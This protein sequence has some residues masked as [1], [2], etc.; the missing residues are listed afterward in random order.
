MRR[1]LDRDKDCLALA[2]LMGFFAARL[3]FA[4]T[5]GLGVDESYT[6]AIS[7]YLSLSYFDHPPLHLWITHFVALIVGETAAVRIPFVFLFVATTWIYYIFTSDLLGRRPALVAL[8]AL[9]VCPFF[10]ASAGGWIVPDGLLLFGLAVAASAASRVFFSKPLDPAS[11]WRRWLLIG[12]GLGLAGLSKYSAVLTAAGLGAF[13]LLSPKQRYW[14]KHP[15]PYVSAAVAIVITTPA[16]VWNAQH[17]WASFEFQG[18]RGAPSGE[19]RPAQ[20][21]TMILGEI[22]FLSPWI[23]APLVSGLINASRRWQDER[24]R[25]LLCLSLPAII[26]FTLTPLW[27][28]RGQPHWAMPGWFFSFAL[29]GAWVDEFGM[30]IG[31]L[32][33]WAIL[34]SALLVA[35][36]GVAILQ[37]STGWPLVLLS[38]RSHRGDPTLEGFE[39]RDLTKAP[40][41][42]PPPRFVISTKW[43]DAGKI[44]LALGPHI[45]VFV[46]S[47]DPRGWAF[48]DESGSFI[49]Q[50]GVVIAP[51]AD[52]ASILAVVSPLFARVGEPQSY[53]LGRLGRSEIELVLIPAFGLKDRLPTP[54]PSATVR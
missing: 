37:V 13:V 47:N 27:G 31:A 33:R 3:F 54:Y 16:I 34:S 24:Y 7:R 41:F 22:A 14:L 21:L 51:A 30:S 1:M 36:A 17:S 32:R 26:L 19:L 46:L 8:F 25:F 9:N 23:F 35:I 48:L 2:I 39:W 43:S 4:L 38:A 44:A 45:P 52:V 49:G 15:A 5:L 11:T 40:I 29:M 42:N 18:A 12:V 50:S 20:F 6:I 28:G 10:F 53:T